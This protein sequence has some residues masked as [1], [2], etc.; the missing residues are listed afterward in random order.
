MS[1]IKANLY[2]ARAHAPAPACI[3]AAQ[4]VIIHRPP[5][6]KIKISLIQTFPYLVI[7]T[8]ARAKYELAFRVAAKSIVHYSLLIS[9]WPILLL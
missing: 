7:N 5:A 8:R 4:E 9:L 6:R 3:R 1:V 2:S